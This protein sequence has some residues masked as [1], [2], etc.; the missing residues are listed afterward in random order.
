MAVA[1]PTITSV[2]PNNGNGTTYSDLLTLSGTDTPGSTV[3]VLD[4]TTVLGTATVETSGNWAFTTNALA[5]G[6]QSFT[7]VDAGVASAPFQM[8]VSP[9]IT[10]FSSV[11]DTGKITMD[12]MLWAPQNAN[13]PWSIAET[14]THS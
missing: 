1:K 7:A 13:Q 2:L 6:A 9:D 14:D 5:D 10:A 4:G 12:G 3:S 8:T 11:S